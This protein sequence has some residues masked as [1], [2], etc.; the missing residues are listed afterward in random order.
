MPSLRQITCGIELGPGNIRLKEYGH[1]VTDGAVE[2][3]VV[4]P[5]IPNIPFH[6]R[7]T[8]DGYIA[9]G[10]S[11][12]VFMDGEYQC[13]RN[14]LRLRFPEDGVSVDEYQIDFKLR[15]R[16]DK[17]SDGTF[18]ARDW[19][20]TPLGTGKYAV[21]SRRCAALTYT[22]IADKAP[23][24]KNFKDNVGT[25]EVVILRCKDGGEEG[26]ATDPA[27][28]T[29][30][31]NPSHTVRIP[32]APASSGRAPPVRALSVHPTPV[33][34]ASAV[35]T[36][37]GKSEGEKSK[38]GSF[39]G[40]M[41]GLFDGAGDD[42]G[43]YRQYRPKN[44]VG[45]EPLPGHKWDAATGQYRYFNDQDPFVNGREAGSR[46]GNPFP[47]DRYRPQTYTV[48]GGFSYQESVQPQE[49]R[50]EGPKVFVPQSSPGYD[51]S[52]RRRKL[53]S[54]DSDQA[55]KSTYDFTRPRKQEVEKRRQESVHPQQTPEK[56]A[57]P[58]KPEQP[59]DGFAFVEY[60]TQQ[61]AEQIDAFKSENEKY[62]ALKEDAKRY[63][64]RKVIHAEILK[65]A[66]RKYDE[67]V[68]IMDS[69]GGL[70][71][72]VKQAMD[73]MDRAT[74]RRASDLLYNKD[75]YP[76]PVFKVAPPPGHDA[77]AKT[78]A[79]PSLA[80]GK[81]DS[82]LGWN[83]VG[84][85]TAGNGQQ[86]SRAP[87][88]VNDSGNNNEN[89]S[90]DSWGNFKPGEEKN[91]GTAGGHSVAKDGKSNDGWGN[92]S[93]KNSVAASDNKSKTETVWTKN[94]NSIGN[95]W[96]NNDDNNPTPGWGEEQPKSGKSKNSWGGGANKEARR[97]SR[98]DDRSKSQHTAAVN[99]GAGSD[100]HSLGDAQPKPVIKPYWSEWTKK[101]VT[102]KPKAQPREV[103]EYPALPLP[104]L[105]GGKA[106]NGI[107]Q[108]VHAGRGANYAHKLR[109]P[110]YLDTMSKPYAIFTFKY[111]S[112]A[113]LEAIL[114][115]K[116]DDSNIGVAEAELKK[117]QLLS[118][119]KDELVEELM[120]K[121]SVAARSKSA[122][123]AATNKKDDWGA[124]DGKAASPERPNG[125]RRS[126][127]KPL[128]ASGW[129][130]CGEVKPS[131]SV[132]QHGSKK[133]AA[134]WVNEKT[135]K[136]ASVNDGW[137]NAGGKNDTP[138]S[139]KES[140]NAWKADSP[141]SRHSSKKDGAKNG[142]GGTAAEWANAGWGDAAKSAKKSTHTAEHWSGEQLPV[143]KAEEKKTEVVW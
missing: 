41:F 33:R 74:W 117:H 23:N 55:P 4:A 92:A 78:E 113:A 81:Q 50:P 71:E 91:A 36:K 48:G 107:S 60:S 83:Q 54:A 85:G 63:H 61:I 18:V 126:S 67:I 53:Q 75:L 95:D 89:K 137:G 125:H 66:H 115:H 121:T 15:Q 1:T 111:R 28:T 110:E 56:P 7:V 29:V 134:G 10:L 22:G 9:P 80:G 106:D 84:E 6:V 68:R 127:S 129:D 39:M 133:S 42:P 5:E 35:R 93:V 38:S 118:K 104:V 119:S 139:K 3:Y 12:Y 124:T 122:S 123:K 49:E 98:N 47:A 97:E 87:T 86:R 11:A 30:S 132:S 128:G 143:K 21:E 76:P 116:V 59:G 130:K 51:F 32:L 19:C 72:I 14:R 140:N 8:S 108:A 103:Y 82:N 26:L 45:Q 131:D 64:D 102:V 40:G 31:R 24:M 136:P 37:G 52:A 96:G 99:D 120:K 70:Y 44:I 2:T 13:N 138:G 101:A 94:D 25:I 90:L 112:K 17:T 58:E 88:A 105:P 73:G 100:Y 142:G 27:Q 114:K 141:A 65:A 79:P 135:T 34:A 77:E 43:Y 109:R 62:A 57:Q 20:F 69:L 46:Y 16:E